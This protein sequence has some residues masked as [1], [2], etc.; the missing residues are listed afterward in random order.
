MQCY[1]GVNCPDCPV[2]K[3]QIKFRAPVIFLFLLFQTDGLCDRDITPKQ[4]PLQ[5]PSCCCKLSATSIVT[6]HHVGYGKASSVRVE[7]DLMN[8]TYDR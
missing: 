2:I 3:R 8:M 7:V 1:F 6:I 4:D 5:R